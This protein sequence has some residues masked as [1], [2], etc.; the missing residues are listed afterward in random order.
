MYKLKEIE[1]ALELLDKYDGQ[2]SKTARELGINRYTLRSRRDKRK[3]N[4]PL[5]K[6]NRNRQSKWT[7]EQR[8]IVVEYYFNHGECIRKTCRKFGYPSFSTLNLWIKKDVRR[9]RKHQIHK[10]P[11]Y[12][13]ENQ[14]QEAIIDLVTR[15][16]SAKIVADKYQV[17]LVTLY[18]RQKEMTGEP[19]MKKP[20]KTKKELETEIEELKKEHIKLEIENKVL[21]KANEILKKE[22][23]VYYSL[24]SNKEKTLVINALKNEYKIKELL[25]IIKVDL[26]SKVR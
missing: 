5:L 24:L 2:L 3:Q 9:K 20:N 10:K 11:T 15:D 17:S 19:I 26:K 22:T 6:R 1:A 8:N 25:K 7:K 12:L 18:E 14:K 21:K 4:I 16:S 13:N 23:G